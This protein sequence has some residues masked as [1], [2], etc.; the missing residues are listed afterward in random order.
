MPATFAI[1]YKDVDP[2][3]LVWFRR[4]LFRVLA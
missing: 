3:F 1:A 4:L 2:R